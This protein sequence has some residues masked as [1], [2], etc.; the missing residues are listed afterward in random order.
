MTPNAATL[1]R[2]GL[3]LDVD[4]RSVVANALL[5]SI[6]DTDDASEVD[7]AWR[8]VVSR[9]FAVMRSGAVEMIDADELFAEM[10]ASVAE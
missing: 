9:R 6:D 1:I 4:E 5:E 8:V 10:R 7:D 3:A 2:D